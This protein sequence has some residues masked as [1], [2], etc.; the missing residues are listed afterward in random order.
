MKV[1]IERDSDQTEDE[2]EE[3]LFKALSAQRNG[4][5]HT[6][7]HF[8]D[9]AMDHAANKMEVSY[10]KMLEDMLLEINGVLDNGA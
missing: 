2:A 9:A 6:G 1:K 7:D 4:N 10:N 8:P 5:A 3:L